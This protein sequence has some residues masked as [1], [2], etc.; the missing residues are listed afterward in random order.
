MTY[1]IVTFGNHLVAMDGML[2]PRYFQVKSHEGLYE[3]ITILCKEEDVEKK[4]QGISK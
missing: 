4:R 2:F 1:V 3:S